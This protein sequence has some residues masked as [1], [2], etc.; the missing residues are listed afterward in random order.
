MRLGIILR[1]VPA[2]WMRPAIHIDERV[3]LPGLFCE[4]PCRLASHVVVPHDTV[5][6]MKIHAWNC[7]L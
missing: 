6:A 7:S 1:G 4:N 2:A 5:L 3:R